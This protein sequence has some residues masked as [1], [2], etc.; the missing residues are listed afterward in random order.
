MIQKGHRGVDGFQNDSEIESDQSIDPVGDRSG[1]V[2]AV[3]RLDPQG[4]PTGPSRL[5][6]HIDA[7]IALE[8]PG[9]IDG[10]S[11]PR[12]SEERDLLCE[13]VEVSKRAVAIGRKAGRK[14]DFEPPARESIQGGGV[15]GN[16]QRLVERQADG[17]GR[18]CE[19]T[20]VRGGGGGR[21]NRKR[22]SARAASRTRDDPEELERQLFGPFEPIEH[23]G[24]GQARRRMAAR[25]KIVVEPDARSH[26]KEHR[27]RVAR[28]PD[29]YTGWMSGIP[30]LRRVRA[31]FATVAATQREH[32]SGVLLGFRPDNRRLGVEQI[33]D[34]AQLGPEL[35]LATVDGLGKVLRILRAARIAYPD[36]ARLLI[37]REER[38]AELLERAI[39]TPLLL[40]L[41]PR[42]RVRFKAWTEGGVE[43]VE[44]VSEVLEDS[45]VFLVLRRQ[46]RF[47]V[48]L[49]RS[50]VIRQRTEYEQ[51]YEVRGIERG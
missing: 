41:R 16:P 39:G 50:Q 31:T 35:D 33:E 48:R 3:G 26:A 6:V 5:R 30:E 29:R 11:R 19:G 27:G 23:G 7:R 37:G 45:D 40:A 51:W 22:G 18:D 12:L 9:Q 28:S 13:A 4:R 14:T 44:D 17:T 15:L 47:P 32:G 49:E 42:S 2:E 46:G 20:G 38:V 43:T 34:F 25:G 10:T 24:K 36:D 1:R 8:A 21:E